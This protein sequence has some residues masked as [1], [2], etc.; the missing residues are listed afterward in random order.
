VPATI[1]E[2]YFTVLL[3]HWTRSKFLTSDNKMHNTLFYT[4]T[5][6]TKLSL[7]LCINRPLHM[8]RFYVKPS[9]GGFKTTSI[10]HSMLILACWMNIVL[11]P[12]KMVL[13][14]TETHVEVD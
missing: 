1:A 9:S 11:N 14:K 12:L 5:K 13:H 4:P 8:F 2:L 6:C 7:L 10:Q 3:W